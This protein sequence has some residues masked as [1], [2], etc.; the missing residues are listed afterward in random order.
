VVEYEFF[1]KMGWDVFPVE[2]GIE[3]GRYGRNWFVLLEEEGK[4]DF[5]DALLFALFGERFDAQ[6]LGRGVGLV[7]GTEEDVV[8]VYGL[9]KGS[10]MWERE[11]GTSA[12]RAAMYFTSPSSE[13]LD[14]TSSV[15]ATGEKTARAPDWRRTAIH[16][17][18]NL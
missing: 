5:L 3:L 10:C 12:S 4:G 9:A 13:T 1:V 15:K 8:L 11:S 18:K 2:L 14:L 17:S 16:I 7:P 6:D